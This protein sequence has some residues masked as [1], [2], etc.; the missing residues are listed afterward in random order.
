M[1]FGIYF[2]APAFN[3]DVL[4]K[5]DDCRGMNS[6]AVADN[7]EFFGQMNTDDVDVAVFVFDC[8]CD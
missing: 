3:D 4:E 7:L 6:G 1:L 8:E 5:L 2:L